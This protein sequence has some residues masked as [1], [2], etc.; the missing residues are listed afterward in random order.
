[1]APADNLFAYLFRS[2]FRKISGPAGASLR[3]TE[4]RQINSACYVSD[5]EIWRTPAP[6]LWREMSG[7]GDADRR[8]DLYRSPIATLAST[9]VLLPST[10]TPIAVKSSGLAATKYIVGSDN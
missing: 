4:K 9:R 6:V 7:T 10:N 5:L 1:M 2:E 3:S 8:Q